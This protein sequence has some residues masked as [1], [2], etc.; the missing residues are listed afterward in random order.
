METP[1]IIGGGKINGSFLE[2]NLI[3]EVIIDI[4]PV[5]LGRGIRLFENIEK[6]VELDFVEHKSVEGGLNIL[7]YKIQK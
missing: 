7:R 4:Q 2:K 1:L 3:D 5:I 6:F